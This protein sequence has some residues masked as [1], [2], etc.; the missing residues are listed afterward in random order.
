MSRWRALFDAQGKYAEI[1]DGE[2]VWVR[3]GK[4]FD[5][6][7]PAPMIMRDIDPYKSMIT[8]EMITSRSRHRDHLRQHNCIEVGNE[9]MSN[10]KN[11]VIKTDRKKV[12]HQQFAD[13]SDRQVK[14]LV[15]QAI[16]ERH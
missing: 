1:E 6:V 14:K 15:K 7:R 16:K 12:L 9:K 4:V 3:P 8:G 13:M 5:E 2:L 10:P 11:P